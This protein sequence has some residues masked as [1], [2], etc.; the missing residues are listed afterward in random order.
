[1]QRG[2]RRLKQAEGGVRTQ[3]R[4]NL[5]GISIRVIMSCLAGLNGRDKVYIDDH[6]TRSHTSH[7]GAEHGSVIKPVFL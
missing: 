6:A 7:N 3:R 2:G 5:N 4:A 1:M